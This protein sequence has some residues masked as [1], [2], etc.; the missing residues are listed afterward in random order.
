MKKSDKEMLRVEFGKAWHD[1]RMRDYCTNQV[2]SYAELPDG[3]IITIDK[4]SIKKHFCFGEHG[5]DF[6]NAVHMANYASESTE[7]FKRE[8]M[9][10]FTEWINDLETSINNGHVDVSGN[11]VL[12]INPIHY[13]GQS[14]DCRLACVSFYQLWAVIDACGGSCN[15]ETLPGRTITI[16]GRENCKVA[17][18]EEIQII[19]AAYKE[20]METHEKRVNTYLKK[21]GMSNVRTWTY[22]ADA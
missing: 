12:V 18:K 21:Y 3:K 16:R 20:A 4:Q 19:L 6:D 8:N 13:T 22:W 2:T 11:Y 10:Y 1:E 17:T 7:Y 15:L 9:K 14:A 5:Y